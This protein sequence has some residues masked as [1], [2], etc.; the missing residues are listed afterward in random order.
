MPSNKNESIFKKIE[1]IKLVCFDCEGVLTLKNRNHLPEFSKNPLHKIDE[2]GLLLLLK[3]N[4]DIAIISAGKSDLL[5]NTFLK[6][7]IKYLY[8]GWKDKLK[9]YEELKTILNIS[10][11]NCCHIGDGDLDIPILEKVEFAVTVPE[12]ADNIKT[13]SD[14]CTNNPG[15]FGAVEELC[16]LIIETK[17]K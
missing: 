8:L 7:G 10:D 16:R 1:K 13:F 6:I 14:Y 17:N 9:A 12:A 2:E 5:K 11:E 3:N 15:G 4:I